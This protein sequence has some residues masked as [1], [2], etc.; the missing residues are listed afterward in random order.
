[1]TIIGNLS[2]V[3]V[4]YVSR[5]E[6]QLEI[7]GNETINSS[8]YVGGNSTFSSDL[9]ITG[10]LLVTGNST[11]T[12]YL[13][14]N[15]PRVLA[16]R[17]DS[18]L[19]GNGTYPSTLDGVY[20]QSGITANCIFDIPMF[21]NY[22]TYNTTTGIWTCPMSGFYTFTTNFIVILPKTSYGVLTT[23]LF[24]NGNLYFANVTTQT[25][26]NNKDLVSNFYTCIKINATL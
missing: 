1:M 15:N 5:T 18:T 24:E 13:K 3:S 26:N 20:T 6:V 12:N 7:V 9:T 4:I 16:M 17:S 2:V 19:L 11:F 14:M 21:D 23:R 25:N 8:L 10:G 22:N